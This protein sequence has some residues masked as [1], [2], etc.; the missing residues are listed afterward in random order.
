MSRS[1]LQANIIDVGDVLVIGRSSSCDI[2][3][4]DSE[5]SRRHAEVS[6]HNGGVVVRDL[7]STNGTS[8]N[9]G[10][11]SSPTTLA[12]GDVIV[13]GTTEIRVVTL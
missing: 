9:G 5:M 6:S 3:V 4:P 11:I 7:G 12:A 13:V 1:P 10:M 8:V 2:H